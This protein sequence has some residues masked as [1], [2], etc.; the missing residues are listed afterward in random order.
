M[1]PTAFLLLA[2]ASTAQW[3]IGRL[4]ILLQVIEPGNQT[5]ESF[6]EVL[7]N[8]GNLSQVNVQLTEGAL[9]T[10]KSSGIILPD[11]KNLTNFAIRVNGS[12]VA[13]DAYLG[14]ITNLTAQDE[15]FSKFLLTQR[16]GCAQFL[17]P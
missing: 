2:T 16:V 10:I 8:P 7:Y 3:F 14:S 12:R 11:V 15:K 1:K 9:A 4:P 17:G 6:I 5:G 13:L